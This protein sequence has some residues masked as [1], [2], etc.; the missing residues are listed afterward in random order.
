MWALLNDMEPNPW[1]QQLDKRNGE[2]G[3]SRVS[4]SLVCSV[5]PLLLFN[6]VVLALRHWVLFLAFAAALPSVDAPPSA[7]PGV[8]VTA[9]KPFDNRGANGSETVGEVLR[10]GEPGLQM[11]VLV[12]DVGWAE[13]AKLPALVQR[14]RPRLLIGLGEG[15]PGRVCIER[16]ARNRRIGHDVFGQE[17]PDHLVEPGGPP[18]RAG[19]LRFDPAWRLS[20][21]IAVVASDDAG[22]YL[23]NALFYTALGD[24]GVAVGRV[25]FIH[26]PPQ[27]GEPDADYTRR[28]VPI[29]R[30]L[31]RRNL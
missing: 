14:L 6:P 11:N 7:P 27:G 21:E 16:V 25:G 26:L 3:M 4:M 30:E 1:G 15:H 2:E 23:C 19:T 28:L 8:L 18:Q 20:G 24:L 29:V 22:T 10:A 17:P 13:P 12:L 31:I 9:F 5:A